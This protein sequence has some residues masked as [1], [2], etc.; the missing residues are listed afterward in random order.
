[1][2][3][4]P[5]VVLDVAGLSPELL[6][7][8]DCCP[9]ITLLSEKNGM[10]SMV[11]SFPSVTCTVQASLTTGQSPSVH[12]IISNGIYNRQTREVNFWG[13]YNAVLESDRIWNKIKKNG[14][15]KLSSS[16][17]FLQNSVYCGAD[18]TM[19]PAPLHTH[20][21]GMIQWCYSKP[22]N[23]YSDTCAQLGT[24]FN[25]M[26][27]WGPMA[28]FDSSRWIFDAG[29]YCLQQHNPDLSFIYLPHL[30]YSSQKYGPK[31]GQVKSDLKKI[32]DLVGELIEYQA[33][34]KIG[35]IILSEYG[36]VEVKKSLAINKIFRQL[37]W[38]KVIT[39]QDKEYI[40][41][42]NSSVF[43]MVDHQAA[44][45]YLQN[46]SVHEV[47]KE[48]ERF[49]EIDMV[50]TSVGKKDFF[51]DH[52]RSGDLIAI[53]KK[54]CWFSYYWWIDDDLAPGF[55]RTMDIHRKPGYDPLELFFD[56]QIKGIPFATELIKGSHGR[57]AKNPDELAVFIADIPNWDYNRLFGSISNNIRDYQAGKAIA[58]L[59]DITI[60]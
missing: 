30:D 10:L 34:N 27:F 5:I 35:I 20:D 60:K 16:A 24:A 48:L 57:P 23:L 26:S 37:G 41:F 33:K 7:L 32:D 58:G 18:Y 49:D 53:A 45:I 3:S 1:M 21:G 40:D 54:N 51:I 9:N 44:H 55:T 22:P 42:E 43:A 14:S 6:A 8:K 50:L 36:L 56:P 2:N 13:R 28:S 31:S 39:I 52:P 19:A 29:M 11:P 15:Q 25:L 47:Q 38:L 59:W 12:G 17:F 4:L 46:I